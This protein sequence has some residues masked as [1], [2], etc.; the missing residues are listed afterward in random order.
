M[1]SESRRTSGEGASSGE[2]P[3]DGRIVEDVQLRLAD[4][5]GIDASDIEVRAEGARVILAGTVPSELAR[6]MAEVVAFEAEGVTGVENALQVRA[7]TRKDAPEP[8]TRRDRQNPIEPGTDSY[9]EASVSPPASAPEPPNDPDNRPGIGTG[10]MPADTSG[11][12]I[13]SGVNL[14]PGP[15][16]AK[17]R[18]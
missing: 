15:R 1:A 6:Q 13:G 11:S 4:D 14:G 3:P 8:P 17:R 9:L 7:R 5:P 12:P 10:G 16:R 2:H 18:G